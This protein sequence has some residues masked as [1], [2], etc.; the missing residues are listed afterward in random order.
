MVK[1][2]YLDHGYGL[3]GF[4]DIYECSLILRFVY[5]KICIF[6][7]LSHHL[8]ILGQ[9]FMDIFRRS[10]GVKADIARYEAKYEEKEEIRR[11]NKELQDAQIAL[12][13]ALKE[14]K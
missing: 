2:S 10:M 3:F 4:Y 14:G 13:K 9:L 5:L 11:K 7:P 6:N 12:E 1:T 8:T